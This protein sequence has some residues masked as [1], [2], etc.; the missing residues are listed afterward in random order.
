MDNYRHLCNELQNN[1]KLELT[2]EYK[3]F[4][5]GGAG[6]SINDINIVIRISSI[7][8][9]E[10]RK[11]YINKYLQYIFHDCNLKL[12]DV[13]L[14]LFKIDKQNQTLTYNDVTVNIRYIRSDEIRIYCMKQI[15]ECFLTLYSFKLSDF[16]TTLLKIDKQKHTLTY[17]DVTTNIKDIQSEEIKNYC[18]N[19]LQS[20]D[21]KDICKYVIDNI[22]FNPHKKVI[23]NLELF[24]SLKS[25]QNKLYILK[26]VFSKY[27]DL[28]ELSDKEEIFKIFIDFPS[29][30]IDL[31]RQMISTNNKNLEYILRN[32]IVSIDR[33]E[34]KK[35]QDYA[36]SLHLFEFTN[37]L[38]IYESL[39]YMLN[40]KVEIKESNLKDELWN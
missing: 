17:K 7:K 38:T 25:S 35:L 39:D 5:W 26:Y 13:N 6:I 18:L 14:T 11:Y 40:D 2:D 30:V 34:Y 3:N 21:D 9:D 16:D 19:E 10:I 37:I 20:A 31:L 28:T 12:S 22:N 27:H 23:L 1:S 24:T 15:P 33:H 36:S 4:L 32:K 8:S 29:F